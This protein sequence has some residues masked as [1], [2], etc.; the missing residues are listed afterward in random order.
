MCMSFI[1]DN[2]Y[3]RVFVSMNP[4]FQ[5]CYN[6]LYISILGLKM[7]ERSIDLVKSVT[8]S[9]QKELLSAYVCGYFLFFF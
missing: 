2:R 3:V 1:S 8:S 6:P 4:E 7:E 5:P 9:T